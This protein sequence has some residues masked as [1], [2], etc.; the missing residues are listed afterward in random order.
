MMI[1]LPPAE[2]PTTCHRPGTD[3]A[4]SR[5]PVRASNLAMVVRFAF[6]LAHE[7]KIRPSAERRPLGSENVRLPVERSK[8]CSGPC[9]PEGLTKSVRD[10]GTADEVVPHVE[11]GQPSAKAAEGA[12]ITTSSSSGSRRLMSR[13]RRSPPERSR[14]SEGAG[15]VWTS[16]ANRLV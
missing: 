10:P 13:I 12:G 2:S 3:D 6:A 4:R 14:T 16:W 11:G 8:A 5:L 1:R 15:A 9:C 7:T